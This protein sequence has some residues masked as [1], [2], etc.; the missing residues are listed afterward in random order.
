MRW[1]IRKKNVDNGRPCS[2]NLRKLCSFTIQIYPEIAKFSRIFN[3]QMPRLINRIERAVIERVVLIAFPA[4]VYFVF[5]LINIKIPAI[6][7][8]K[9][10][11]KQVS[12]TTS[13]T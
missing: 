6:F 10:Y 4:R 9:S 3:C 12:S 11:I 7:S 8:T 13:V 5:K 2:S 1:S